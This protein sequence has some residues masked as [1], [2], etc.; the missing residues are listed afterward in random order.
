MSKI[1]DIL[2]GRSTPESRW[3]RLGPYYAMFPLEFAFETVEEYSKKGDFILDPFAGRFSSIFAGSVTGR[4]GVG[5]EINPVG[6]LYG[7]AKIHPAYM[8]QVL[9]RLRFIYLKRNNYKRTMENMPTFYRLCFCDDVLKFLLS[10]RKNLKWK[11]LKIDATLMSIILVYLHGKIGQSLSNQMKMT[12]AMGMNYSIN[13]WKENNMKTPP[14][15]NPYDFL[16]NRIKW[17]YGKGL[18][19]TELETET[20]LGDST[21]ILLN[22][23]KT[24]QNKFSLLFTS[25]PYCSVTNYYSDQWLRYW[26]LGGAG[27]PLT[28]NEKHKDRF[29]NKLEYYDLLNDVFEN[30]SYLMKKKSTIYVRTDIRQFTLE[31]TI[32]ILKRNFPDHKMRKITADVDKRTQTDIMGNSS[33]KRGEIDIIMQR[34]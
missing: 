24:K 25:P 17:R 7:K 29:N 30:C 28:L 33:L 23:V 6:W 8:D 13:W 20:I 11:R 15:I 31:T 14:E 27:N 34:K 2:H 22:M 21:K 5:I 4:K 18:P 1:N 26:M 32:N 16:K 12:K 9:E 10:A 19:Q 3:A